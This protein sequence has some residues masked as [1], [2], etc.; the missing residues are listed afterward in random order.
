MVRLGVHLFG[1]H[2]QVRFARR[3]CERMARLTAEGLDR[4]ETT[5]TVPRAGEQV[6]VRSVDSLP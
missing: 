1:R 4:E 6:L 2:Q 5:A 3:A